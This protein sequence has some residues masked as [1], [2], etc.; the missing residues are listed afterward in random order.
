MMSGLRNAA[1]SLLHEG[2]SL[3]FTSFIYNLPFVKENKLF[4]CIFFIF[5]FFYKEEN[6]KEK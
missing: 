4:F 2:L 1:T 3:C 5:L 6:K